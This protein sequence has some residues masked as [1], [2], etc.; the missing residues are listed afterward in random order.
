MAAIDVFVLPSAYEGFP[1]VLIEAT[2]LGL[3]IVTTTSANA[4]LLLDGALHVRT[5]DQGD[6]E[7]MALGCVDLFGVSE[8]SP[9]RRLSSSDTAEDALGPYRELM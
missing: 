3:P 6:F 5:C 1:Y 2:Y 9:D 8:R 4:A 7:S